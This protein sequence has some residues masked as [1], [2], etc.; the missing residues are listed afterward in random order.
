MLTLSACDTLLTN[1]YGFV[2]DVPPRAT[3]PVAGTRCDRVWSGW[4][5]VD[6]QGRV[7]RC[8]WSSTNG[9]RWRLATERR[10]PRPL[11]LVYGD[12]LV[13]EARSALEAAL[14]PGWATVFRIYGGTAPCDFSADADRDVRMYHPDVVITSFSGNSLTA[15]TGL[16]TGD[17]LAAN[18]RSA[19]TTIATVATSGGAVAVLS[20][21]PPPATPLLTDRAT[22]ITAAAW[23][24]ALDL[25]GSGRRAGAS[26]DGVVLADPTDPHV[27][28]MTLPCLP[29]EEEICVDGSAVVRNAD[30]IHLCPLGPPPATSPTP[31][32]VRSPGAERFGAALAETIKAAFAGAPLPHPAPEPLAG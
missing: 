11:V 7:V 26:N 30:G 6:A 18:Y 32:D 20:A 29:G 9:Y 27:G 14:G 23:Q 21:A 2:V 10:E 22:S 13:V 1:R 3:A 31:C 28:A 5:S 16:A 12:S 8:R 25:Q 19:L 24:V 17:D 4:G 15:C